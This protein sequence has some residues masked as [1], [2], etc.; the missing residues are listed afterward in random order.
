MTAEQAKRDEFNLELQDAIQKLLRE[1]GMKLIA[2]S[3]NYDLQFGPHGPY[4]SLKV[5]FQEL[6]TSG[7]V[8]PATGETARLS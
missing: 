2:S 7:P 6:D 8:V 1:Y 4:H 3:I 5:E